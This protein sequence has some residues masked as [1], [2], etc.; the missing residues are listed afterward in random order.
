MSAVTTRGRASSHELAS[1]AARVATMVTI[2]MMKCGNA[3]RTAAA[4]FD[5][6]EVMRVSRSPELDDST[7]PSGR[8]ST[9]RTTSSRAAASVS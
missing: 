4:I 8:R 6:S 7:W 5:T 9:M 3:Q 2:E 1:I